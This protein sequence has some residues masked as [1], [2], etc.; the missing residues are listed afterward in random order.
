[1]TDYQQQPAPPYA[2]GGGASGPRSGFWI[3]FAAT[4]IDSLLYDIKEPD[5]KSRP[6]EG[7]GKRMQVALEQKWLESTRQMYIGV[8]SPLSVDD[9][10]KLL[11]K[12]GQLDMKIGS[13]DR[14]DE[15]FR[16][17]Q[18]GLKFAHRIGDRS[19]HAASPEAAA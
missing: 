10:V 3:R 12:S 16:L 13:S 5:Y 14:V 2:G 6:F 9:C 4:L 18:A 8:Q 17:G 15:I 19:G 11:T 1:M 7:A